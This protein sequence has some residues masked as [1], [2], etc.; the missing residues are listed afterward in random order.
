M[1]IRNLGLSLAISA[2]LSALLFLLLLTVTK[3]LQNVNSNSLKAS[4]RLLKRS[5]MIPETK[6]SI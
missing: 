1:N 3:N 6:K 4:S 5:L 2:L